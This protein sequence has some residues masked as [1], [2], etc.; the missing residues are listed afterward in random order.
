[1][2][3]AVPGARN[4]FP[5]AEPRD[6]VS[7]RPVDVETP[8]GQAPKGRSTRFKNWTQESL[9]T[10]RWVVCLQVRRLRGRVRAR[11]LDCLR[12]C[13]RRERSERTYLDVFSPVATLR[14]P[15]RPRVGVQARSPARRTATIPFHSAIDAT[16]RKARGGRGD[17]GRRTRPT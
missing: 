7:V 4:V 6:P 11:P 12:L 15:A 8:P 2:R 16:S 1:L 3:S 9:F 17:P 13:V 5:A 14:C 10:R